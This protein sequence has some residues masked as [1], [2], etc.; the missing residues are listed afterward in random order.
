MIVQL[1]LATLLAL[2][3][4]VADNKYE[5][6]AYSE[7][8][9]PSVDPSVF[10][11]HDIHGIWYLQA[12][13]EPTTK[14]CL[15]NVMNF[16]IGSLIYRYTDTCFEDLSARKT[17]SNQTVTIGG[18]L[19]TN[20]STPGILH[21]GFVIANHSIAEKPNMLF[22]VTRDPVTGELTEMHFY[23]CLGQLL[24]F[25][26]PV[27]SYLYYTREAKVPM[28]QVQNA[29]ARDVALYNFDVERLIYTN[30]TNWETCGVL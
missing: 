20:A 5:C 2:T 4:V 30:K 21:E 23:A 26:K 11:I 8:R 27:F 16:S 18:H 14:F 7:I 10:N 13:T 17:W 29:V 19:S 25:T 3:V 24:P 1:I 12:T 9:Q 22:N 28:S 15:C 6:P